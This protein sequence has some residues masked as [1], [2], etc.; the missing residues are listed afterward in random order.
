[1]ANDVDDQMY[2]SFLKVYNTQAKHIDVRHECIRFMK[3]N[4]E[5]FKGVSYL[6]KAVF[7][8]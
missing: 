2:D 8:H 3:A 6:M 1:M 5:C 7:D 4:S